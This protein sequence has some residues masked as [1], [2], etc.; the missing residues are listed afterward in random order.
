MQGKRTLPMPKTSHM[1][2]LSTHYTLYK[3]AITVNI[4]SEFTKEKRAN[5]SVKAEVIAA[6]FMFV[7]R[8][9]FGII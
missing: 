3:T 1:T 2:R 5:G 6:A 4:E 7:F 9:L 8:V